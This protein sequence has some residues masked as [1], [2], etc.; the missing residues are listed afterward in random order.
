MPPPVPPPARLILALNAGSSSIKLALFTIDDVREIA[1]GSLEL[2]DD[3][4]VLALSLRGQRATLPLDAPDTE[5]M[6]E[7]ARA[8]FAALE[9]HEALGALATAAHRVVHG[10]R[11]FVGPVRVDAATLDE[12][13]ALTPL[14][15]LHQP[16]SVRLMRAIRAMRPDLPQTA[17]FDTAFH[18]TQD[19]LLRRFALPRQLHDD[20]V[21]R[22]GFHGLSYTWIARVL[23]RDEPSVAAGRV[24]AL[25]LGNGASLCAMLGGRSVD[26]SMGFSTLDGVP[27]GTRCGALDPGVPLYLMKERGMSVDAVEDL[28]YHRSGLLGVSGLS[29]DVRQLAAAA[30]ANQHAAQALALFAMRCAGEVGR[31]AASLQGLD[32]L[33]FTAGIGEHDAGMRAAIAR[34]LGWLGVAL[35]ASTN[36]RHARRI[37]AAGSRVPVFVIPADEEQVIATDAVALLEGRA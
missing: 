15:P 28:L 4:H 16:R 25:H 36:A 6:Q 33:V 5:S 20:G 14:A 8:L 12:I 11:R 3:R 2:Q 26:S 32:A 13:D 21:L 22:Y 27:M 18:A 23:A 7:V 31:L 19:P 10:G 9:S 17:S 34:R 30:D 35:D 24:V 29:S 37:D 1:R